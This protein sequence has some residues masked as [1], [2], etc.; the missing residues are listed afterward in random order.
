MKYTKKLSVSLIIALLASPLTSYAED[1]ESLKN[2]H[3]LIQ[4]KSNNSKK[5][6]DSVKGK[7]STTQSKL[8]NIAKEISE[9]N[10]KIQKKEKIISETDTKIVKL[11]KQIEKT[12][13]KLEEKKEALSKNLRVMYMEGDVS[14]LEYVFRSESVSDFLDRYDLMKRVAKANEILYEEVRK[15]KTDLEN[16]KEKL[17]KERKILIQDKKKLVELKNNQE[18]NKTQ[19]KS[20]LNKLVN[21][22]KMIVQDMHDQEDAMAQISQQISEEI[23]RR[24]Q[25]RKARLEAERI[26][27][28]QQQSNS[29]SNSNSS[30]QSS[31]VSFSEPIGTGQMIIPMGGQY[32]ISSHFGYRIHPIFGTRKL[33]NGTD[34]AANY[35]TPIIAADSGTV[36][37]A[38]PAQ[39]YGNWVVIDHNNGLYTTYGHMPLNSITVYPGQ[40]VHRGQKIAEVGTEGNSTGPHLHFVVSEGSFYNYVDPMQFF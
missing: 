38:G 28:L 4:E 9:T 27:K 37:Y 7:I 22:E 20:L 10:T 1:L 21:D 17:S 40:E 39:G 6:L 24:E 19:E 23:A 30:S 35:G 14:M 18:K 3:E 31:E 32:V 36:L 29:Q 12:N 25:Q 26:R 16:K 11:E 8:K 13:K 2:E 15:L 33:H 34:F 5:E